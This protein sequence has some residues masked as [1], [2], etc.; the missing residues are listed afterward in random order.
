MKKAIWLLPT[1]AALAAGVCGTPAAAQS[2]QLYGSIRLAINHVKVGQQSS[3][4]EM[5]DNASR[6]GFKGT[7]SLGNGLTAV[8]GME[9]GLNAT[10]GAQTSQLRNS[11]VGLRHASLG[12]LVAG[13][14]DSAAVGGSPLYSQ[15]GAIVSYA[16]NDAGLTAIGTTIANAR[17]RVSNAQGYMSPDWAGWSFRARYYQRGENTATTSQ[18][19]AS[20]FDMGVQYNNKLVRA[21]LGYGKDKRKGG[22]ENNEFDAKWQAGL[23][24]LAL[25]DFQPYVFYGRDSYRATTSTRRHVNYWIVGAR[26]SIGPHAIT[27]NTAEREVQNS[28]SSERRRYQLS[29]V[30]TLTKRT[31]LQ[32]YYDR[33]SVDSSRDNVRINGFGAGILHNF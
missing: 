1:S 29:Y 5:A 31:Q 16:P 11:Y 20:S 17:N 14:L 8:W 25:G 12:S 3:T 21:A 33:D 32:A 2:T 19:D 7:E 24:L 27:A 23:R 28:L 9:Y 26:Y 13:R 18:D 15:L 10:T 6:L 22:L 4:T 30:Y